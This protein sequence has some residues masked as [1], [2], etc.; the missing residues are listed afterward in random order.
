MRIESSFEPWAHVLY[1]EKKR[2]VSLCP[3][4]RHIR[5]LTFLR[6]KNNGVV[7]DERNML[8]LTRKWRKGKSTNVLRVQK[9]FLFFLPLFHFFSR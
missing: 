5:V 7:K 1:S 3:Q 4:T 2:N 8:S 6:E 9:K